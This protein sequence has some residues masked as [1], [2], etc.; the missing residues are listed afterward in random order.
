MTEEPST[1]SIMTEEPST[2]SIETEEPTVTSSEI[3]KPKILVVGTHRE[4]EDKSKESREDKEKKLREILQPYNA[5]IIMNDGK[6][7]FPIDS[8]SRKN[9]DKVIR[10]EIRN[11]RTYQAFNT[12]TFTIL[13]FRTGTRAAG[14]EGKA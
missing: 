11:I 3:I 6:Y 7:I 2:T 5:D 12:I 13:C 8:I 14:K 4:E 10:G 9:S 1:T